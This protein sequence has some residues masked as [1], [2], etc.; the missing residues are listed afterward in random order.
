MLIASATGIVTGCIVYQIMK[1]RKQ[2]PIPPIVLESKEDFVL[3]DEDEKSVA[4]TTEIVSETEEDAD[5]DIAR[6][7]D[8]S[9]TD[10]A[11]WVCSSCGYHDKCHCTPCRHKVCPNCKS[12]MNKAETHIDF[13]TTET[14]GDICEAFKK[15]C[16]GEKAIKELVC[17]IKAQTPKEK[18][19]WDSKEDK[20]AKTFEKHTGECHKRSI[21]KES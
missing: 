3:K 16:I 4:C 17:I 18:C 6:W 7:I 20:Y 19:V 5:K 21:K 15:Y 10:E 1:K 9:F 8:V 12:K 2:K 13:I 14:G 11:E